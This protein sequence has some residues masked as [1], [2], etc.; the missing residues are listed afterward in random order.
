M[1]GG[2]LMS[3]KFFVD[4]PDPGNVGNPD[5]PMICIGEFE[6]REEAIAFCQKYV[7]TDEN[8][9]LDLISEVEEDSD[10]F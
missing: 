7:G 4:L 5:A 3:K 6:T 2:A 9:K 8:G 1:A 10:E